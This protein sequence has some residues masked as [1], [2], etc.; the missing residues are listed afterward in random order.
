MPRI[1]FGN[2][3][4]HAPPQCASN[5][6]AYLKLNNSVNVKCNPLFFIKH[7]TFWMNKH[8][9]LSLP[10]F[11]PFFLS[12]QKCVFSSDAR[13]VELLNCRSL[14]LSPSIKFQR[15]GGQ[16]TMTMPNIR[17]TQ[18]NESSKQSYSNQNDAPANVNEQNK[19][20][21]ESLSV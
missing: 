2:H 17:S 8:A 21:C 10:L 4:I 11:F 5:V 3:S 20:P 14:M 6:C 19:W 9:S 12:L 13:T 15:K 18:K 16:E 1:P 7:Q